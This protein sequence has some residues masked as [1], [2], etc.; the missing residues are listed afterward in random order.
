MAM[1]R[2]RLVI[3]RLEH[4]WTRRR[5]SA[6]VDDELSRRQRLRLERHTGVCPECGRMLRTLAAL[7]LQL[8]G[9]RVRGDASV[10]PG[11]LIRVR[12][13]DESSAGAETGQ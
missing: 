8:H 2:E 4:R 13:A 7:L 5:M 10:A 3:A 12:E 9:L 1:G 11:V 6:Y